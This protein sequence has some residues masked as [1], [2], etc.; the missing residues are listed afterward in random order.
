[1]R[2]SRATIGGTF[3]GT[4]IHA[5]GVYRQS[6]Q[7]MTERRREITK[8]TG[9][10]AVR[11][12]EYDITTACPGRE[13]YRPGA[14]SVRQLLGFR[15]DDGNTCSSSQR[16]EAGSLLIQLCNQLRR[17]AAAQRLAG[18]L[19]RGSQR[20]Q[21]GRVLGRGARSEASDRLEKL[22]GRGS[23]LAGPHLDDQSARQEQ[24]L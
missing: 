16:Y 21:Q 20:P 10:R 15:G 6:E 2:D 24:R 12:P 22:S 17:L 18:A 13:H 19:G 8:L 14:R 5:T 1:M 3:W 11:K 9:R 4:P 7:M 23:D